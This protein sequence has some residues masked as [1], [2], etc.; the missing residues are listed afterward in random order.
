V[1]EQSALLQATVSLELTANG[2]IDVAPKLSSDVAKL[3]AFSST[4]SLDGEDLL[5]ET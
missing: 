1:D 3:T 2:E 5:H 4:L